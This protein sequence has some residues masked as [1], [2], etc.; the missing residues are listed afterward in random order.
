MDTAKQ[1]GV[2]LVPLRLIMFLIK[3]SQTNCHDIYK[4]AHKLFFLVAGFTKLKYVY[5]T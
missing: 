2:W 3:N 1:T 4:L 5:T